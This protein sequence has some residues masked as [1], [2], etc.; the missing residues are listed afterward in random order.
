MSH[1]APPA[2]HIKYDPTPEQRAAMDRA[3][4]GHS[5]RG[6]NPGQYKRRDEHDRRAHG[7]RIVPYNS[8]LVKV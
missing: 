6:H 7:D 5:F 3:K 4:R 2:P 8:R 1:S